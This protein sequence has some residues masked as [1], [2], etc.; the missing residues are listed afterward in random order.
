M[1]AHLCGRT[2]RRAP[3]IAPFSGANGA[4]VRGPKEGNTVSEAVMQDVSP[5]AANLSMELDQVFGAL[6]DH[7]NRLK[8]RSASLDE[9]E[10]TLREAQKS[11]A[12]VEKQLT[13]RAKAMGEQ[14]RQIAQARSDIET[15]MA[16]MNDRQA[17]LAAEETRLKT[18]RED[19]DRVQAE[20][21]AERNRFEEREQ[22]LAQRESLLISSRDQMLGFLTQIG[23]LQH[24]IESAITAPPAAVASPPNAA[25][26]EH[27][28]G[29]D[30]DPALAKLRR[31][32]KRRAMG[33]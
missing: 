2:A 13:E 3:P 23:S 25:A 4:S 15:A 20:I 22:Q 26:T 30:S 8:A 17:R 12:E 9:Q 21:A 29:A 24:E 10:Q 6:R 5:V 11:L 16:A 18:V 14:E 32:V 28:E 19:L 1:S 31:D 7:E 27:A 33:V